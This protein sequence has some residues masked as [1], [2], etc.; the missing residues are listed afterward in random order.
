MR[1]RTARAA[2]RALLACVALL[3]V[4]GL[5][6]Q[7][8]AR[9]TVDLLADY[10]IRLDG[11]APLDQAGTSVASAGDVNGD[12]RRDLI[13][14][15]L[16]ADNNGR[17]DSGSAYVIYGPPASPSGP[18]D[19]ADTNGAGAGGGVD[20]ADGFRIDGAADGDQAGTSVAAAGDVNG[21]GLGDLIVGAPSGDYNGR[22]E[23]G[24]AYV[25]YGRAA[26]PSGPLDLADT[27]GGAAGDGV[28]PADGFRI[29][30]AT[31]G[32]QAGY[33]VAAAGDVNG[34]GRSD[35]ILGAP[36]ADDNGRSF[37]GSAYVV[38]GRAASPS[39]P[40]DLADTTGAA[41]GGGVDPADG[42][43][44]NG[45]AGFDFAGVSVAAAGDVNGDG[46]G[47]VLLG[48]TGTGYNGRG[49]A[50]SAYVIYGRAASPSGPIDLADTN[51]GAPGDGVDPADGFRIDGAAAG[52]QTGFSVA[53]AGDVNGD[54]RGDLIVGAYGASSNGRSGA[55]SAYVI[56]GPPA[57]PSGP[58]DLA[59]TNGGAAGD[60]VDPADG[61]RIDGAAGDDRAGYSV[62]A[63]GDVNSDGRGDVIVGARTAGNNERQYSGSAYVIYGRGSAGP[64]DLADT[65]GSAAGD[66]VDPAHGFRIDGA[67]AGDDAGYSVGSA[68]DFDG[69]GRSDVIVGAPGAGNNGRR[70]SGSAYVIYGRDIPP[71]AVDDSATTNEDS[72]GTAIDVLANDTDPDGGP[73]QVDSTTQPAHGTAAVTRHGAKVAYT[74]DPGYCNTQPGGSADSFTYTLN[75]GSTATVTVT[76]TCV[77][78]APL[79]R[80]D[81]ATSVTQDSATL[82]GTVNGDGAATTYYF[83][84]GTTTGYGS[85]V[86]AS[87]ADA[88]SGYENRSVSQPLTGLEPG[89]TYHFRIVATNS[90]GTTRGADQVFTTSAADG[91]PAPT[92]PTARTGRAGDVRSTSAT[93]SGSINPNG[94]ATRYWFDY[95]TNTAYAKSVFDSAPRAALLA[96]STDAQTVPAGTSTVRVGAT[97]RGLEPGALYHY[98]LVAQNDG[99]T[100]TGG[101][102]TF[103]TKARIAVAGVRRS[104]CRR[105]RTTARVRVTSRLRPNVTITLDGR[106]VASGKRRSFRVRIDRRKLRAGN[107]RLSV[108]SVN[109]ATKTRRTVTF[110]VCAAGLGLTG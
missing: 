54:G 102:R 51:G 89:T 3:A 44:I 30:G 24:A 27:N 82:N 110:R 88:G 59:D 99:G 69:D 66:G 40:I 38:Y 35:V 2:M 22:S 43:R 64:I 37:S 71:S 17:S 19:L 8:S 5:T 94:S 74:P 57:S 83:E 75:G 45:A 98:R 1:G 33:S 31:E 62:A 36:A 29:D 42:L 6:A 61:F 68:G 16:V 52:D 56:Y 96:K 84:Y 50:G 63:A 78:D 80:T 48:A 101:D 53:G 90:G 11:A 109:A 104:D 4:P 12:G 92:A 41:P 77:A 32:D 79:A 108:R 25:I 13:V 70:F 7:A 100:S 76:V 91:E 15:A 87:D 97:L 106:R 103:G 65:N 86:P 26:S 46:R 20:P 73:K 10:D 55:G 47:D 21:D 39:G 95:G 23:S 85:R 34:D 9:S 18:V 105:S 60:G 107:H 81:A 28:D 58:I 49:G 14:G 93:V 72:T 67:A